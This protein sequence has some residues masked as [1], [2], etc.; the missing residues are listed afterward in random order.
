MDSQVA[1]LCVFFCTG[2]G[3]TS[4]LEIPIL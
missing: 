4:V 3:I 1:L 2:A